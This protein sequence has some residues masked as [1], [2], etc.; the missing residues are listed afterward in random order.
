MAELTSCVIHEVTEHY[1]SK[2]CGKCGILGRKLGGKH[3]FNCPNCKQ[4]KI[5]RDF[6]GARNIFMKNFE[7][8]VDTL[9]LEKF[10]SLGWELV[11]TTLC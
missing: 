10:I 7:Q 2:T 9:S 11:P 6:N 1:T 4:F 8:C 5:N 3:E